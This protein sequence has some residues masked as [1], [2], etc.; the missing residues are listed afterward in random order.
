MEVSRV[1]YCYARVAALNEHVVLEPLFGLFWYRR[2]RRL[3]AYLYVLDTC[4]GVL[5][6]VL[7]YRQHG[8]PTAHQRDPWSYNCSVYSFT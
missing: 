4:N 6:F 1:L 2:R 7:C 5:V 3:H 8:R